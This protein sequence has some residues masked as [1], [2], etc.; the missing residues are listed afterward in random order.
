[1]SKELI[2]LGPAPADE[3]CA[4]TQDRDFERRSTAE[5]LAYIQAIKRVCGE[6]PEGATL[7]IQANK[8]ARFDVVY[9]E[10]VVEYD[11]AIKAAAKYALKC[12]EHAPTTWAQAGMQPAIR[13][14]RRW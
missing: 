14:I 6:P 2:Y 12:E 8:H 11:P 5:C 7:R 9:R 3:T 1:V 10:V 4:Q 13:G